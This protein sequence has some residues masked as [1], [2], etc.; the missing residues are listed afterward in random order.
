MAVLDGRVLA[1]HARALLLPHVEAAVIAGR[2]GA[3]P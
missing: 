2:D 3:I 1:E